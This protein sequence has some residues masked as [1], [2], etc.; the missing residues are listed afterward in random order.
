VSKTLP[1]TRPELIELHMV[2]RRR[3]AAAPLGSDE[4]RAACEEIAAIEVR[5]AEIE[6]PARAATG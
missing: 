3:R 5:I 2:A 4:Y 6:Q 1:K